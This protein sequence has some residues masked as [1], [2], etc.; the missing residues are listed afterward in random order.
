MAPRLNRQLL[1]ESPAR[2][3]DGA[4]GFTQSWM[5]MGSL[6]A[7]VTA[8]TGR[9]A[10][11]VAAPMSRIAY[12]IIVRAAPVGAQSRPKPDQRFVEGDRVFLILSVT[13]ND[14]DGR[15][16]ICTAQEETVA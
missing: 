10:A 2:V 4:G 7:E 15:Y 11:G 14:A 5:P 1:L 8:R 9:E 6:W 16:L 12:K 13:E 3:P